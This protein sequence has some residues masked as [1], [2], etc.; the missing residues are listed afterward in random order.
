MACLEEN[1]YVVAAH[2]GVQAACLLVEAK[3]ASRIAGYAVPEFVQSPGRD[4]GFRSFWALTFAL[5]NV[6][7]ARRTR[8]YDHRWFGRLGDARC[9]CGLSARAEPR[10]DEQQGC[11]GNP[12]SHLTCLRHFQRSQCHGVTETQVEGASGRYVGRGEVPRSSRRAFQPSSQ[13]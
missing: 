11:G 9:S 5:L 8:R 2:Q 6:L 12:T 4:T 13:R 10:C 1:G 7:A 3:G